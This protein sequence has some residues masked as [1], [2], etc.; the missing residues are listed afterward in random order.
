MGKKSRIKIEPFRPL[1]RQSETAHREVEGGVSGKS[2]NRVQF[3]TS[4]A[5]N[6]LEGWCG[7]RHIVSR[8]I[9]LGKPNQDPFMVHL[10]GKLTPVACRI[11]GKIRAQGEQL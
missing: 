9:Q 6:A 5:C 1:H 4:P 10:T 2:D 8:H 3:R 11:Q 7:D